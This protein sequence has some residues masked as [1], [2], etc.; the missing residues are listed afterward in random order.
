MIYEYPCDDE[1]PDDFDD[2]FYDEEEDFGS[3]DELEMLPC[4]HCGAD[5]FEESEQCPECGEYVTFS[6]SAWS[7]RSWWWIALGLLGVVSVT[8]ALVFVWI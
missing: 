5:I 4:P 1:A 8:V 3:E 2:D 6:T 7:G